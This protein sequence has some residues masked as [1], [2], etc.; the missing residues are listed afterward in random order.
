M[1]KLAPDLINKV[2]IVQ[3]PVVDWS[4]GVSFQEDGGRYLIGVG[5]MDLKD[6]NWVVAAAHELFH[7]FQR[8][9]APAGDSRRTYFTDLSME[10]EAAIF[11][12]TVAA[13]LFGSLDV[14]EIM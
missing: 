12:N 1:F 4:G 3:I 6:P 11:G 14:R 9:R 13:G 2:D 8:I 5:P 10:R 7:T